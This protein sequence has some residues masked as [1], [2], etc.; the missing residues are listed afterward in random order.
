MVAG[1]GCWKNKSCGTKCGEVYYAHPYS[2]WKRGSNENGNRILRRYIPKG[3]DI[4]NITDEELQR[5][6][7]WVNNCPRRIF[8]YKSAIEMAA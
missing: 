3:T 4:G 2:S 1:C 6:E 7:N 8:S 5:I